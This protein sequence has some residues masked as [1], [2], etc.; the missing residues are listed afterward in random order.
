MPLAQ[1]AVRQRGP[2]APLGGGGSDA[3]DHDGGVGQDLLQVLVVL[4]LVQAVA[5]LLG[6]ERAGRGPG[7]QEAL[8]PLTLLHPPDLYPGHSPASPHSWQLRCSK[9]PHR[10][11]RAG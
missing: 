3:D 1:T 10:L 5:Q 7:T 9:D 8:E 4:A 6:G 11:P 2:C